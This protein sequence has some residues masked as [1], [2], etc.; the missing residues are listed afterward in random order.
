MSLFTELKRRNVFRVGIAYLIVAWLL[1][2]VADV[3]ID[4]IG[5]PGWLFQA[6]LLVLGIGFP[7]VLVFAWAFELTPE[8]LRRESE[9]DHSSSIT[10]QTG[11]KLDRAIIVVLVIAVAYFIWES[12]YAGK[13]MIETASESPA[14]D[15][16]AQAQAGTSAN[17]AESPTEPSI[18]VLPFSDLSPEGDQGYFSDGIA[19]ELLNLLVRVKGL[20]VASRTSSFAFKGGQ[21]GLAEIAAELKVDHVL[22]GSVRK[23]ANRVRI[24]AQLIDADTDRHLW[25]D[26]FDRELTDIFAIQDEIANAIVGALQNELGLLQ[27][28]GEI[29]VT[30]DTGNLDAY[31]LYLRGRQLFLARDRLPESIALFEQAIELDPDFAR[32]WE[33]LAAVESVAQGWLAGDG[34]DHLGKSFEAARR[35][36]ELDPDLSMPYAV[37]GTSSAQRDGDVFTTMENL[38]RAIENDANNATAWLWRGLRFKDLGYF[39]RAVDDLE[40][41][42][43]IDPAYLNCKQH[44]AEAHLLA[45]DG[46]RAERLFEETLEGNFFSVTD[47]FVS[48]YLRSGQRATALL[49]AGIYMDDPNARS[50]DWIDALEHPERDWTDRVEWWRQWAA[51]INWSLCDTEAFALALKQWECADTGSRGR[52]L[53]LPEAAGFRKTEDFKRLVRKKWLGY[54][55]AHGFPPRCR[56]V[57]Q[58][59]FE[60]D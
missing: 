15:A 25:S 44:L 38:D 21:Q 24:T 8:G 10:A 53:W 3:M 22:E 40:H 1:V 56:A 2:Q 48:H 26:T 45:G 20:K 41:C 33:G 27:D 49:L 29:T 43:A 55:Q 47:A 14:V 28:A 5:A 42:L 39:Q 34:V 52:N 23:A 51:G 12:R 60:C 11:R 32:A 31:E 36:L 16:P 59:D 30:A 54:W 6:I 4:N 19:E 37:I 7:L 35:A 46:E 13:S 9:V 58:D 57:G 18:A 17:R 50:A